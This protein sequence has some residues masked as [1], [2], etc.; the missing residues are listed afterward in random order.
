MQWTCR[1]MNEAYSVPSSLLDVASHS[2]QRAE[3]GGWV[4][5]EPP[6]HDLTLSCPYDEVGFGKGVFTNPCTIHKEHR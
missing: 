6:A 4:G 1:E 3:Q 2:L 5:P